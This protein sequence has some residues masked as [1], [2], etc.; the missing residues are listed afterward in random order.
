MFRI[1]HNNRNIYILVNLPTSMRRKL[2]GQKD[3]LT[4]TLPKQ[5]TEARHLKSGDE[6]DINVLENDIIISSNEFKGDLKEVVIDL[7]QNHYEHS[8]TSENLAHLYRVNYN[9]ITFINANAKQIAKIE[10]TTKQLLLGFEIT[11]KDKNSCTVENISEPTDQ[12]FDT[13]LRRI[14]LLVNEMH[15][16][17][18]EDAKNKKYTHKKE[19]EDLIN[20]QNKFSLFCKKILLKHASTT[21]NIL[22]WELLTFLLHI[23]H[24]YKYLYKY[25]CENNVKYS[26]ESLRLL[27]ELNPYFNLFYNA[28]YK[29]DMSYIHK[30][31]ELTAKYHYGDCYNLL[32]NVSGDEVI[33]A[34]HIREVYRLIQIG[35]SPIR[36]LIMS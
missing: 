1:L 3:S 21:I 24:A 22:Q 13:I 32:K 27:S 18:Y 33:I 29:K 14:M 5:W 25:S 11:K 34:Y 28:Y 23:G 20:M 15:D 35:G 12:K 4:I 31:S 16:L 7:K 30:L 6:I 17:I 8:L 26:K 19:I 2:I 36:A 10:E 9:K